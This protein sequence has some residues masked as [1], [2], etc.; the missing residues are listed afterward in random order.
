MQFL[1]CW[2][3]I[4]LAWQHWLRSSDDGDTGDDDARLQTVTPTAAA[5]DDDNDEDD[6]VADGAQNVRC[7][8]PSVPAPALRSPPCP[9]A[10]LHSWLSERGGGGCPANKFAYFIE[11]FNQMKDTNAGPETEWERERE[12]QPRQEELKRGQSQSQVKAFSV[13]SSVFFFIFFSLFSF[14][15]Q[16]GKMQALRLSPK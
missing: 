6:H 10:A 15:L 1:A 9:G 5:D 11:Q 8:S 7:D 14:L 3:A 16:R 4:L 13:A 12:R 2:I